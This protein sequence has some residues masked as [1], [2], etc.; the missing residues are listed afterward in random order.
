VE[1]VREALAARGFPRQVELQHLQV[2]DPLGDNVVR[3]RGA[4]AG[5]A[6]ERGRHERRVAQRVELG[7][8]LA[9]LL[10]AASET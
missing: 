6:L 2:V 1:V 4:C 10:H 3:D 9:Q 8:R 5:A 7:R